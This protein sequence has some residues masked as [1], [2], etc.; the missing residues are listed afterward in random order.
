M[1]L[2]SIRIGQIYDKTTTSKYKVIKI[3]PSAESIDV[4]AAYTQAIGPDVIA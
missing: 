1:F 3:K 4:S 2:G